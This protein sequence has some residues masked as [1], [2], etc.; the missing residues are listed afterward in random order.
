MT[1]RGGGIFATSSNQKSFISMRNITGT[2]NK[3]MYGGTIYAEA[4]STLNHLKALKTSK[5]KS[6]TR[7]DT[8]ESTLHLVL[9][10]R[11]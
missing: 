2:N 4:N 1:G 6:K 8:K 11:G 10:L 9:R 7:K 3:A 5:L